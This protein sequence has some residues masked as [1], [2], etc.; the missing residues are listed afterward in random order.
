MVDLDELVTVHYCSVHPSLLWHYSIGKHSK[1]YTPS[2]T[3]QEVVRCTKGL[4]HTDS[5]QESFREIF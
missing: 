1:N 2:F 5:C 3:L 4:K